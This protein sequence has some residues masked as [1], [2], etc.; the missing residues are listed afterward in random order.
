M[1]GVTGK[2]VAITGAAGGLGRAYALH[3]AECGA[4]VA[5]VDVNE[6][7]GRATAGEAGGGR[8]KFF[9]CDVSDQSAVQK[10]VDDVAASLGPI[11]VMINN[12]GGTFRAPGPMESFTLEHWNRII[13]VNLTGTWLFCQAVL[14]GMKHK[15]RGKIINI[16]STTFSTG[17]PVGLSPYIAS[18]G[19]VVALTRALAREWGPLNITVNGIAPSLVL[20]DKLDKRDDATTSALRKI[21]DLVVGQQS[22]PRAET[23]ADLVG[24]VEFL[25][26]DASNF[27]TGQVLN[28]D[29]GWT[30]M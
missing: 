17:I 29:G 5:I 16:S 7:Q 9:L 8:A 26:S 25:V 11:D 27:I 13:A 21:N 18:K 6:E 12:A 15:G 14:P 19:G 20:M 4:K 30:H 24:T 28:V 1:E 10:T 22:L 23:P 3:L 2:V